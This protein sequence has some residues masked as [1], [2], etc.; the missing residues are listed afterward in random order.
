MSAL[1]QRIGCSQ[2]SASSPSL[3]PRARGGWGAASAPVPAVSRTGDDGAGSGLGSQGESLKAQGGLAGSRAQ[4]DFR[5]VSQPL[6]DPTSSRATWPLCLGATLLSGLPC[7][8]AHPPF[9]RNTRD[10]AAPWRQLAAGPLPSLR[11]PLPPRRPLAPAASQFHKGL[12]LRLVSGDST[13]E[14]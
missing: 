1:T 7:S 2:G 10:G 3:P 5:P 14:A 6:P 8:A 11:A 9:E 4:G 12:K 13:Q